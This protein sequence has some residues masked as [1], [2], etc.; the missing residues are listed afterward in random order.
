MANMI[1]FK[2][3]KPQRLDVQALRDFADEVTRD[4][5]DDIDQLFHATTQDFATEV[6][7]EREYSRTDSQ[8]RGFI[9]TDEARYF[10]LSEGTKERY[11]VMSDDFEP[12]TQPGRIPSEAGAGGVLFYTTNPMPGI[13]AREFEVQIAE[14]LRPKFERRAF[15][16]V[17]VAI[18]K[19]GHAI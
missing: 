7:F 2:P 15:E 19:S 12:K 4:I 10:Y 9:Y 16:G 5:T 17:R 14:E 6:P 1:S 18:K 13:E 8:C 11:V 3:I